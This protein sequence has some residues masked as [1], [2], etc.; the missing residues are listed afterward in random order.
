M[1][2]HYCM[3]QSEINDPR[4]QTYD[5]ITIADPHDIHLFE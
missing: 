5:S 1:E 2:H 3:E 4:P